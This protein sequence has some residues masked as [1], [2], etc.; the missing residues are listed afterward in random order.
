MKSCRME[1]SHVIFQP[2][3]ETMNR[4]SLQKLQSDR[5]RDTVLH[6][7]ERVPFYKQKFDELGIRPEDIRGVQDL[8]RLPFTTKSHFREYYPFGLFAVEQKDVIRLHGSSGT[9]GKPTV[10]GYTKRDIQNWSECVARAIVAAGGTPR[11]MFHVLYG[12]GLFTGGLGLHYG[13]ERLEMTVVPVSGGNTN[14]Q[15][16]LIEDFKPKGIASTPSYLL[17]VAETMEAMGREPRQTSLKYGILGA[18]PWSEEMRVTLEQKLG[19]KAL[20]IYGLS[21]VMGPGVGIEC[22]EA[23]DGL[24]IAEDH[25]LVEIVNPETG[26]PVPAGELGEVVF[27]SLTKE[28][29][30]VIRYRTGDLAYLYQDTCRCGRSHVRMSRIKGRLDDM[31]IVRGVNVFPSEIEAVVMNIAELAPYYQIIV[32]RNGAMDEM[33][34]LV[35]VSER[36]TRAVGG[37]NLQ[38]DAFKSLD[39]KLGQQLQNALGVGTKVTL[40][41]PGKLPRSDGK[42]VRVVDKRHLYSIDR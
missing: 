12:Y 37:F 28:A 22:A 17:T 14:R 23:Q 11:D 10:V 2:E 39:F 20:D 16:T 15:V 29:L 42:A 24:H 38:H 31:L 32:D 13:A 27:T 41:E 36:L 9:K 6:V 35:E 25:F 26:D 19:I 4:E 21:E 8:Q 5:L 30:P 33:T 3:I 18:E 1:V 34:L 40:C 7:Y